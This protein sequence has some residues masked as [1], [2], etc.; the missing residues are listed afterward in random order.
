VQKGI[1]GRVLYWGGR[2]SEKFVRCYKKKEL[3]CYRVELELHSRVLRDANV[4]TPDDIDGLGVVIHPRHCQFVDV[5]WRH[6]ERYL[7][8]K[9][10]GDALIRGAKKRANSISRLRRYLRRHGIVNFHRL[11]VAL[12]INKQIDRALTRWMGNFQDIP[13]GKPR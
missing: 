9:D 3:G 4:L 5:D 13:C 11:L 12:P 8:Q 10:N 1:K 7:R 2:K 6:L